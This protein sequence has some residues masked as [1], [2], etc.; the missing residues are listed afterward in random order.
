MN[1]DEKKSA[2]ATTPTA[3]PNERQEQNLVQDAEPVK[4]DGIVVS[5]VQSATDKTTTDRDVAAILAD[6]QNGKWKSQ[7][8]RIRQVYAEAA[9]DPKKAVAGLKKQ[10]PGIL[11]SGRFEKRSNEGLLQHSGILCADLDNIKDRIPE[12]REKLKASPYVLCITISPTGTG[13]KVLFRVQPDASRHL[14]SFKAVKEHV[15]ELTGCEIDESCKDVAR[16]CFVS[17][18]PELW[19]NPNASVIPITLIVPPEQPP[20]ALKKEAPKM[21]LACGEISVM[22]LPSKGVSIS[23]SARAIC[24]RIE[25]TRSLFWRGGALVECTEADGI[26]SLSPVKPDGFRSRVERV[27]RVMA[28]RSDRNGEPTLSPAIMSVDTAKALMATVEA[29]ELL[30]P[31]TSVLRCPFMVETTPGEVNILCRGY[32][33]ENGGTFVVLGE[34]PPQVPIAEAAASLHWLVEEFAFQSPGDKSR[35]LAAFITPAL[36][37][38]GFLT[39]PIPVD[40]AEADQSQS[41]KGYRH[42]LVSSL[43][44]EH[45]YMIT[46]RVGGVGSFD[47]SLSSALVAGRPFICIDNLRGQIKS[48]TFE[49][50]MTSPGRVTARVPNCEEVQVDPKP[51]N[52]QLSSNG[53]ESTTDLANRSSICRNR[54]RHGFTYRDTLGELQARQP[55]F[56]GCVLSVIAEWISFGKPRTKDCRHDFRE[57]SQTL[58]WICREILGCAP[59]MDGHEEAQQR[60][61]N[62]ALTWLRLVA[63]ALPSDRLCCSMTAS[64]LAEQSQV[65]GIDIPGDPHSEDESIKQ[66]GR[67]CARVFKDSNLIEIEGFTV[68]RRLESQD[69]G[70]GRGFIESKRYVFTKL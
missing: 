30:P 3:Q 5:I 48:Q 23:E 22:I 54:K 21:L 34:K 58:D 61:A 52:L 1:D 50:L 63:L 69:R 10:L 24:T 27:G 2:V 49:S 17:Y 28:W 44:N 29:R 19:A 40:V 38:G 9:E 45:P 18:D 25:P 39:K 60:V 41:G 8:D 6:L 64:D 26:A 35:A 20:T 36:R 7:V 42:T 31:I 59:L 12:V 13:L 51:F 53:M 33:D 55:Y 67:I 11:W 37:M 66:I 70:E 14:A 68:T 15:L 57:W 46:V 62:P 43:Y 65:H 4:L 32:H 16:L 47:E 56:L